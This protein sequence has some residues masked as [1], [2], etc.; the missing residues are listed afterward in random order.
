MWNAA[1]TSQRRTGCAP[2]QQKPP[3]RDA[4]QPFAARQ[5]VGR[6]TD[7]GD[8]QISPSGAPIDQEGLLRYIVSLRNHNGFH[9]H[10]GNASSLDILRHCRP[11]R[12]TVYARYTRRGNRHQPL[13]QPPGT[14][15]RPT[16]AIGKTITLP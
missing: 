12:L 1:I 3:D 4:H 13:H 16:C 9:E 10:R 11:S 7:W 5:L 6:T 8:I 14:L 2:I 15:C